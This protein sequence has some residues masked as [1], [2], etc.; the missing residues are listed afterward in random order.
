MLLVVVGWNVL[1][2]CASF[3][4]KYVNTWCFKLLNGS[5]QLPASMT[6][7]YPQKEKKEKR[8]PGHNNW[9]GVREN[10]A[11]TKLFW[12]LQER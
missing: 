2:T 6:A 5:F 11:H 9:P 7:W 10:A 12:V 4:F 1:L 3:S 8:E